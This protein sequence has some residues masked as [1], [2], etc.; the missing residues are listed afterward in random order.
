MSGRDAAIRTVRVMRWQGALPFSGAGPRKPAMRQ[1]GPCALPLWG[2]AR[3]V[4]KG[5]C[6]PSAK[7]SRHYQGERELGLARKG[8]SMKKYDY[9]TVVALITFVIAVLTK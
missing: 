2:Q 8:E 7:G 1:S 6:R 5:A 4:A 3:G 9:L